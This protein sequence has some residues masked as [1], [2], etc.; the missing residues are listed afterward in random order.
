MGCIESIIKQIYLAD[1]IYLFLDYDGTVVGFRKSPCDAEPSE[2]D[3]R[4]LRGP[5]LFSDH[6]G[7][8]FAGQS[9]DSNFVATVLSK[10][11]GIIDFS[12]G[13][14]PDFFSGSI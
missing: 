2:M 13:R 12:D 3:A 8:A 14:R 9:D 5:F 1:R 7:R 11:S 4:C 6:R 10:N